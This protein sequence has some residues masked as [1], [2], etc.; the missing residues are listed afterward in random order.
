MI[1][2]FNRWKTHNGSKPVL[3]ITTILSKRY[4]VA[5]HKRKKAYILYTEG[6]TGSAWHDSRKEARPNYTRINLRYGRESR[7][8]ERLF[9]F[10]CHQP[11]PNFQTITN[12]AGG[13]LE[14]KGAPANK[15]SHGELAVAL[16]A[17]YIQMRR[18][19]NLHNVFFFLLFPPFFCV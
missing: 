10:T 6:E 15:A 19:G 12:K 4:R 1:F 14:T 7:G 2:L 3:S 11:F 5:L 17:I 18:A 16:L 8:S 9:A 13:S